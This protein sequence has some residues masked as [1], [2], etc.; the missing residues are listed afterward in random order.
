MLTNEY[1]C[2]IRPHV[3]K[4]DTEGHD[5]SVVES[6]VNDATPAN[7]L[8]LLILWEAKYYGTDSR[9]A[10]AMKKYLAMKEYLEKRGYV[11]SIPGVDVCAILLHPDSPMMK[12]NKMVGGQ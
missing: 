1:R 10:R 11:L 4:I 3:L 8:P 7:R 12:K 6:F 2:K 5:Q 9:K